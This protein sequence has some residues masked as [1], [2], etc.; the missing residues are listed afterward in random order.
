MHDQIYDNQKLNNIFVSLEKT[1][2]AKSNVLLVC[3]EFALNAR[4][5]VVVCLKLFDVFMYDVV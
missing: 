4:L 2:I 5:A 3:G 1:K